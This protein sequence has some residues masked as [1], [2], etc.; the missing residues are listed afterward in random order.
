MQAFAIKL[1]KVIVI[2]FYVALFVGLAL[3]DEKPNDEMVKEMARLLPEVIE[4]NNACVAFIGFASPK[5]IS[6][7][8]YGAEKIQK[9]KDALQTRKITGKI[10][11][12][13]DDKKGELSFEGEIPPYSIS[14]AGKTLEYASKHSDEITQLS[15]KNKELLK[16]Y[17]M[18]YEYTHYT[19]P[20]DYGYWCYPFPGYRL[21]SGAQ[22]IKLFQMAVRASRGDVAGALAWVRKDADFWRFIVRNTTTT[23]STGSS[24]LIPDLLFTAEVGA[25]LPLNK[26]EQEMLQEILRPFDQGETNMTKTMLG[27]PRFVITEMGLWDIWIPQRERVFELNKF[28]LKQNATQNRIYA[29]YQ[30]YVPLAG[31][32]PQEFAIE[33]KTPKYANSDRIGISFLYNPEGEIFAQL[34]APLMGLI[35]EVGHRLEGIRRLALLKVLASKEKVS[36]EKMQRF[37]DD[38]AK[39]LG[40]P[41]TGGSMMWNPEKRSIYFTG[42]IMKRP[43]EVFL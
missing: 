4:P 19:E 6:P 38:H 36:S 34:S 14:R 30:K 16:R 18:L 31:L 28:F 20:L 27:E 43:V 7:Y 12:P 24:S 33:M 9:L 1:T 41:F 8:D 42:P 23:M 35:I 11:N 39:D 3:Y 32:R 21:I 40:N 17:E 26:K 29:I 5:G 37:L 15:R 22:R 2:T 10:T 13:F 25:H